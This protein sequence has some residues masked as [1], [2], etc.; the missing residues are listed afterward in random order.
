M[1][2]LAGGDEDILPHVSAVARGLAECSSGEQKR[3]NEA[4]QSVCAHVP[5]RKPN[6]PNQIAES[7]TQ[8]SRSRF[9]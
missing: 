2:L 3:Q 5:P 8:I 4:I 9:R 6:L 1:H 7:D